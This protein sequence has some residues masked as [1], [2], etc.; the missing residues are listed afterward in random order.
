MDYDEYMKKENERRSIAID[1][2]KNGVEFVDINSAY[3]DPQVKIGAGTVIGPCVT[4]E[5]ATVIGEGCHIFQNTRIQDSE[6]GD[7]VEIQSSVIIES[8]VGKDTKVGPFA[9]LRPG[10][11]IGEACKVGDF[12][13]VKNSN[14]GDGSKTAHLTYIGDADVGKNVNI[15]C[16]VVFVNYDG[17]N[18]YRST[19]G[20]GA[21]IG[22]N[23]NLV[24]PVNVEDGAYIAAGS[25]VT[26]NVPEDAL[27]IARSK[28]RN[29]EGWAAARGLYNKKDK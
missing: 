5:G 9:Y 23:T 14:F 16:G 27:C 29:I 3:I 6:I 18:K 25:T 11:H 28:Q 15:G 2:L 1:H 26:K 4:L 17:T 21:F 24:S 8:S 12:V 19:V 13:E 7:G 22:C 20:N 10:S